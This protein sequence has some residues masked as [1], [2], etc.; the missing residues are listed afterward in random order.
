M[1]R[2][3][4]LAGKRVLLVE[5]DFLLMDFMARALESSG[6]E[7]VGPASTVAEALEVIGRT[8]HLDAAVLDIN[9]RGEM[10]FGIADRL[11]AHG[12]PFVFAT[13]YSTS[14]LPPRFRRI[15]LCPKP[16]EPATLAEMMAANRQ[17]GMGAEAERP[18]DRPL[19]SKPS[20]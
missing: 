14:V 5:D 20:S 11:M 2:D 19:L 17:D 12:V 13:G 18:G 6:A 15:S 3:Q 7:V 9:L 8:A 16:V 10:S 1:A 4:I